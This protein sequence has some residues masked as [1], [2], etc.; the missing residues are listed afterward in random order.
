MV[1]KVLLIIAITLLLIAS[2]GG[3]S[4]IKETKFNV[5]WIMVVI[6]LL[7]LAGLAVLRYILS[8]RIVSE[9][10]S[11][12]L[13]LASTWLTLAVSVCLCIGVYYA[14]KLVMYIDRIN[15]QKQLTNKRILSTVLRTE[16]KERIRFSKELHDGLGPLLSSAKMSL[17]VIDKSNLSESDVEILRGTTQVIEEAVRSLREISNNLSPHVLNEFGLGRGISNFVTKIATINK[18]G[19]DYKSGIGSRRF[20]TD[21]EVIL[22]RVVCELVGNSLRHSGCTR[23]GIALNATSDTLTIEYNDNGHG[24]RPEAT[25]SGMGLSNIS[26]RIGSLNGSFEL[27]SAPGQG[28]KA[29]ISVKFK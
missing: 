8:V 3:I 11:P 15:F 13:A 26:S 5:V 28:M 1:I 23:I 7:S 27:E 14:R 16:E 2:I 24:F 19:I 29:L 4:L 22:Y 20:D 6:A 10:H 17:S 25:Y 21:I 9:V 18:V 12:G